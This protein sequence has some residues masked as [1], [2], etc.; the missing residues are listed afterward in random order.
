MSFIFENGKELLLCS[1]VLMVTAISYWNYKPDNLS[2][3]NQWSDPHLRNVTV[4]NT[5][6]NQNCDHYCDWYHM[7]L[8]SWS[9]KD[10]FIEF[11]FELLKTIFF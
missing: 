2:E 4:H 1:G 10:I 6:I 9:S 5:K 7:M 3:I 8:D 11:L